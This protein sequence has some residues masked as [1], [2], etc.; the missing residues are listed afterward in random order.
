[1]RPLNVLKINLRNLLR[2]H[3]LKLVLRIRFKPIFDV[4][5]LFILLL[6]HRLPLKPLLFELI[7]LIDDVI[8]RGR[9]FFGG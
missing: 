1:M 5:N 8:H 2:D 9:G 7:D 4:P 6:D 3:P